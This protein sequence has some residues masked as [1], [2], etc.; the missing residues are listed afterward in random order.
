LEE[1]QIRENL[2][3][4]LFRRVVAAQESERQRIARD[5]HDETGQALTAIGMGLRG[6]ST[7]LTNSRNRDQAISTLR[8]L[9]NLAASSLQE[10]QRLIT[11]LRPSHLDDLGLP[12]A[13]RWYA[14]QIQEHT[15]LKVRVDIEGDEEPVTSI[16][17]TTIFRIVQE[18]LNN[19]IK[20]SQA[21]DV[22]IRLEY[23]NAQVFVSIRDDGVGFDLNATRISRSRRPS[24][25][26]AGMQ[27]R[28][29]LLGGDVK[30][31]SSPGQGTLVEATLPLQSD[32]SEVWDENPPA[33]GR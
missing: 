5:L 30:I 7:S 17:K 4:E 3:S 6:L 14:S 23:R 13:L 24:L 10:L 2:K 27:E 21:K 9:E 12:A 22:N 29:A 28:A 20:H 8:R 19:I 33:P 1:A 16:L 11:D 32:E 25:G 26:L 18:A 31:Q 15:E